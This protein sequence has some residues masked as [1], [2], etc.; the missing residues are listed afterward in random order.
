MQQILT[1]WRKHGWE[2]LLLL[3]LLFWLK[4]TCGEKKKRQKENYVYAHPQLESPLRLKQL[5]SSLW[6]EAVCVETPEIA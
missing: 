4:E 2:P 6:L 3:F 5:K 1:A